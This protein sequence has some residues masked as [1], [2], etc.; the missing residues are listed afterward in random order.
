MAKGSGT[1]RASGSRNPSGI[2]NQANGGGQYFISGRVDNWNP[3][4]YGMN[5]DDAA[6]LAEKEKGLTR[7][8]T[9]KVNAVY[10]AFRIQ[11]NEYSNPDLME[12]RETSMGNWRL[13]YANHDTGTTIS[14]QVISKYIAR[15]AG[16]L[17]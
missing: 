7:Y 1:T 12:I 11:T 16:L 14:K 17:K 10:D 15:K 9:E 5:G 13:Y 4:V 6:K 2:N 3:R 8:E